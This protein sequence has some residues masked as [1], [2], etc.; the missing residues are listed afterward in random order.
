MTE[1]TLDQ[2]IL[3]SSLKK[4]N[5]HVIDDL[6]FPMGAKKQV[7]VGLRGRAIDLEELTG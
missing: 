7:K 5:L 4:K 2:V 3:A 6:V 1:I